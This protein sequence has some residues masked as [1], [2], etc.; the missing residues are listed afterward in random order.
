M[1]HLSA[2]A[3]EPFSPVSV[4]E[5]CCGI[6]SQDFRESFLS[7]W[8]RINNFKDSNLLGELRPKGGLVRAWTVR[9]TMHT[10]PSKDY[11][12][13]VFGSGRKRIL[14]R[15]DSWAKRLGIPPREVRIKSLYQ[16]LLDQI[17]GKP[18]TSEYIKKHMIERLEKLGLKSRMRL[19]RGWSSEPTYGPAWTG[20][21]EMSY[22]GLLVSAGRRGSES[23]WMRT[24]DWLNSGRKVPE[25]EDCMIELVRRYIQR[26][27]PVSRS[28]ITYWSNLLLA[29]EVNRCI[30]TLRKDLVQEE[31]AG[32]KEIF[33]MLGAAS[34]DFV[35]PPK[36]IILPEFDSLIMG[37]KDRSR[38]LSSDKLKYVSKP[39]GII[40]PTILVDGFVA[41]TWRKKRA[42]DRMIVGVTAFKS[43]KGREKRSI[44]ERFTEYGDY[45]GTRILVKFSGLS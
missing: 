35:E 18:V 36:T 39:Q 41:A 33:Y 23:L 24:S 8:A 42:R 11:Y 15:Y 43:L 7:F 16:P 20:I 4:S 9:G 13:H 21:T 2:K 28:D 17:K 38:F 45:L 22:L 31:V 30:E 19:R 29:E 37:Y 40:S 6:N 26:Y 10:F 34:N 1:Q 27:G 44:E 32:S 25:P 14:S 3:S 5:G 12:V